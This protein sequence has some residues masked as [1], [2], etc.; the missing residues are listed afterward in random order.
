MLLSLIEE[1]KF[2]INEISLAKVANQY[3]EYIK[4][5]ED[6]PLEDAAGFLSIASTLI[7]I[8][9]RSLLPYFQLS[10]E[11]EEDIKDLEVRLALYQK[12]REISSD[13]KESFGRK[14]LFVSLNGS[15]RNLFLA[16]LEKKFYPPKGLN[17]ALL[18]K[19]VE[20]FLAAFASEKAAALPQTTV[21]K[22]I[23]LEEKINE[24]KNRLRESFKTSFH[25]F[26]GSR[27]KIEVIV[28]FLAMLE[29]IKIGIIMV[30]QKEAFG[31]ISIAR[32]SA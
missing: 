11:E 31:D 4:S 23:T 2:S 17:P 32:R 29:L 14:I 7:L 28:S 8:K 26:T 12:I 24:L 15:R 20:E 30:E 21:E 6:F 22:V 13:I 19:A 1:K 10:K 16:G 9:S 18:Q 3:L 5:F 25:S 27:K